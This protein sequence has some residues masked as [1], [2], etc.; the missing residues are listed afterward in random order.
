MKKRYF[1]AL[2]P[3]FIASCANIPEKAPHKE[4]ISDKNV[5]NMDMSVNGINLPHFPHVENETTCKNNIK[6]MSLQGN[7][8]SGSCYNSAGIPVSQHYYINGEKL[9]KEMFFTIK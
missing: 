6:Q 9:S 1:L 2:T 5:T 7:R 4:E 8:A 3:F